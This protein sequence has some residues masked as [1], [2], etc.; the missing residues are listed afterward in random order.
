MQTKS[1]LA[2]FVLICGCTLAAAQQTSQPALKID[3]TNR[4]LTV[5]AVAHVTVPS[6]TAVIHI[7]FETQLGDAKQVYADGARISN[8]IVEALKAAGI[9]ETAIQSESQSLDRDWNKQH[10][11]K[12]TQQWTVKAPAGRAAEILDIAI[13]AG[14]TSSGQIDW[15]L[16]DMKALEAQALE[17]A[18]ERVSEKARV[19]AKGMGVKLGPL[20]YVTSEAAEPQIP[21]WRSMAKSLEFDRSPAAPAPPLAIEPQKISSEAHVYAVFTIE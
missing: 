4:I 16:K 17:Q 21:V 7:G 6:D 1:A 13:S 14:A 19:L 20:V 18:T 8:T 2:I 3:S 9:P 15:T 11:F 12:L 5:S 10:K